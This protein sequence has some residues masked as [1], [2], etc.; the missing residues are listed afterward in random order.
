MRPEEN[1]LVVDIE[2]GNLAHHEAQSLLELM[3]NYYSWTY[4]K[5][6]NILHGDV[7]EIGC[8]AGLGIGN[9]LH[10]VSHVYAVDY[11]DELLR[12][13]A[14]TYPADRV[15]TVKAD[16]RGGWKELEGLHGDAVIM[17]DVLEHFADDADFFSKAAGMIKPGGHLIVK[18]PA[19][20]AL[21]SEMDQASG[22]FRRYDAGGLRRL[23][24][25]ANLRT[26]RLSPINPVGGLAYRFKNKNKTNFSKS[27]SPAQLK[28]INAFIPLIALFDM[29]PF[30]PGLSIVGV[31]QRPLGKAGS[32][33]IRS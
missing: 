32:T 17:M 5:F 31:F 23:A 21:Y 11:N 9:Y 1:Q 16:L 25:A 8:G 14:N 6:K 2:E 27:F 12:R 3:P 10:Q 4:G 28:L 7:I 29:L 22:H 15:T 33:E 13:I 20:S 18:V 19:Q 24:A 26:I 30:L